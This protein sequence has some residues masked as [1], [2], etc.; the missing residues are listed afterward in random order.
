MPRVE[1]FCLKTSAEL[2]QLEE[3]W[4]SIMAAGDPEGVALMLRL[5]LAHMTDTS[6]R[7]LSAMV[8]DRLDVEEGATA[9]KAAGHQGLQRAAEA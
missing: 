2:D 7:L 1:Q 4:E 9:L 6:K 3:S 8:L 5:L